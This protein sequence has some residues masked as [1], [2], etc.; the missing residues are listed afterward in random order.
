MDRVILIQSAEGEAC[1]RLA[2]WAKRFD[3]GVTCVRVPTF[4]SARAYLSGPNAKVDLAFVEV[5]S[6]LDSE[7]RAFWQSRDCG[8]LPLV[9]LADETQNLALAACRPSPAFPRS[10]A[11]LAPSREQVTRALGGDLRGGMGVWLWDPHEKNRFGPPAY[12]RELPFSFFKESPR[13]SELKTLDK[14]RFALLV[15]ELTSSTNQ[16]PFQWREWCREIESSGIASLA[17]LGAAFVTSL[18]NHAA[19]AAGVS[20]ERVLDI[21]APVPRWDE[22]REALRR[23]VDR[24]K[25]VRGFLREAEFFLR[26]AVPA[27]AIGILEHAVSVFPAAAPLWEKLGESR[28]AAKD[29]EK[30]RDALQR[31]IYLDPGNRGRWTRLA[32]LLSG[33]PRETALAALLREATESFPWDFE[34]RQRLGEG[35]LRRGDRA[36]SGIELSRSVLLA[37]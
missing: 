37:P 19:V 36:A 7:A 34:L 2:L 18:R 9:A 24:A 21:G 27:H 14:A 30:G 22:M 25:Q 13:L 6:L 28:L 20:A 31:A 1:D 33:A 12:L 17:V 35:F 4:E 15:C 11:R 3:L 16:A 32:D 23:E 26:K 8:A 5:A 10:A 29:G